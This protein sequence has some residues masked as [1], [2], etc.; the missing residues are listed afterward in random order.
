MKLE[1]SHHRHQRFQERRDETC[2][3]SKTAFKNFSLV[4]CKNGF[5]CFFLRKQY[6]FGKCFVI[7]LFYLMY[8]A[9]METIKVL[10]YVYL[11]LKTTFER[12]FRRKKQQLQFLRK[13][14]SLHVLL[15]L[16]LVRF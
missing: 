13:I 1:T 6:M 16:S 10:L 8:M 3:N 7:S 5:F 2:K 12:N 15:F 9:I 11:H 4:L 14:G